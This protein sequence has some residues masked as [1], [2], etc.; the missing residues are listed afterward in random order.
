MILKVFQVPAD[1]PLTW[2]V[3]YLDTEIQDLVGYKQKLDEQKAG[4]E[5]NE[6]RR[7][8]RRRIGSNGIEANALARTAPIGFDDEKGIRKDLCQG[9]VC[10]ICCDDL[11]TD[12][13]SVV[14]CRRGCGQNVHIACMKHW[15]THRAELGQQVSCPMCRGPWAA[16]AQAPTDAQ[17]ELKKLHVAQLAQLPSH[18]AM[19]CRH[20]RATPIRGARYHC[21]VCADPGYDLCETCFTSRVGMSKWLHG[22]HP[23]VM[24]EVDD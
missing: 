24:R 20:C 5:Y 15:A 2:Q 13:T 9:D 1:D 16:D 18:F 4:E 11:G 6:K 19:C 22:H 10:P 17:V 7:K 23:F 21:L 8:G 3:A 14:F 12:P